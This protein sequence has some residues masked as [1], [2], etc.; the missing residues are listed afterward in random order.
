M[1]L[2]EVA[3]KLLTAASATAVETGSDTLEYSPIPA[4]VIAAIL[5]VYDWFFPP[6]LLGR[7]ES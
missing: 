1:E 6:T 4:A 7:P 2:V 3:V 5:T